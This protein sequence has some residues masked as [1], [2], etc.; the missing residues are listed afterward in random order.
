LRGE[1]AERRLAARA[2]HVVV[3]LDRLD[4]LLRPLGRGVLDPA[5][6][7]GRVEVVERGPRLREHV[8]VDA[9]RDELEHAHAGSV[10]LARE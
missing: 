7:V 6:R 8:G 10:Q 9:A 4:D 3:V 1:L 2:D 5:V